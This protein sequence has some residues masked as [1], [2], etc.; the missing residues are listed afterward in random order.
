M[1][2]MTN[3]FKMHH[4]RCS[5]T[6]GDIFPH[7]LTIVLIAINCDLFKQCLRECGVVYENVDKVQWHA[8]D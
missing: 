5:S 3:Y 1:S 8:K 6:N 4:I 2:L 7:H